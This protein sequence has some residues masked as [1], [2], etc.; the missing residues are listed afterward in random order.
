MRKLNRT[1]KLAFFNARIRKGDIINIAENTL[2]SRSHISNIIAG[3]RTI[4]T[5]VANK[6]YRIS[7]Q[8]MKN[9]TLVTN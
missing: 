9:S 4:P 8:R 5:I 6:M 3:R 7:C 1:A 2:Y